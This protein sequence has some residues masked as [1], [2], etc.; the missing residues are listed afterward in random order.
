[1]LT[2]ANV[3]GEPLGISI[4]ISGGDGNRWAKIGAETCGHAHS[5]RADIQ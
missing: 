3:T 5:G 4:R 1:L 2:L